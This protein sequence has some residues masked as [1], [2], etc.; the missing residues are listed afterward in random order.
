MGR[1]TLPPAIAQQMNAQRKTRGAGAGRPR[2]EAPRCPCGIMT[3]TR[4][5]ARGKSFDHDPSCPW[6]RERAIIV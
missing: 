6:Y 3:L 5:Q 2:S 4:A 1:H